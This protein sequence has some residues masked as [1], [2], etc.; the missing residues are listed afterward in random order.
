MPIITLQ[1]ED[2]ESL[3][4]SDKDTIIERV[5]MIGADIERI[6][7]KSIDIEFFPDRP[8]LYSVE[9]VARAMRGFMNIETGLCQYE[10]RPS[11]INIELDEQ[12]ENVRP[13]LG[14]AVVKGIKFTSSSIKSLMDL[15]ES[16]HWG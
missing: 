14:C 8:D 11:D 6:E 3:T 5:P 9:G 2:L 7:K 1:Y 10:I 15:Q 4:H 12:I 13:V 16:L